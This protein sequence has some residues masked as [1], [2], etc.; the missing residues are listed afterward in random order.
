MLKI[1]E[2]I[3]KS[4]QKIK[5][6]PI[7]MGATEDIR[8]QLETQATGKAAT[9]APSGQSSIMERLEAA[10]AAEGSRDI[11]KGLQKTAEK[12]SV[13][14][15]I[16][17][18]GRQERDSARKLAEN[19]LKLE[20][21]SVIDGLLTQVQSSD[22][23]LDKAENELRLEAAS[24]LLRRQNKEYLHNL[25]LARQ[26]ARID[27]KKSFAEELERVIIGNNTK[28]WL[29]DIEFKKEEGAKQR[30]FKEEMS[31]NDLDM[32]EKY[33]KA[34]YQDAQEAAYWGGAATLA[35]A[36]VT[37]AYSDKRKPTK[38]KKIKRPV[39]V[40]DWQ[41]SEFSDHA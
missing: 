25:A 24:S 15:R 2:N 5:E 33:L 36:G 4:A 12:A 1:A 16:S 23:E 26:Y 32:A 6:Q 34:K 40:E 21:A 18:L 9:T 11:Q 17:D 30:G 22:M 38:K 3:K 37:Y 13:D 28:S 41:V 8:K 39:E 35:G 29:D 31:I 10:K 19:R 20:K 14:E 7:G 27:D